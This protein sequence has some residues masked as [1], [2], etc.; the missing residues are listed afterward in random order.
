MLCVIYYSVIDNL[1]C[2][3]SKVCYIYMC[4]PRATALTLLSYSFILN[5][6]IHYILWCCCRGAAAV[7]LLPWCC[8]RGA[9][10]VVLLSWC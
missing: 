8:C 1:R 5:L 2:I 9:A 4:T 10:V 3:A 6:F 7:V